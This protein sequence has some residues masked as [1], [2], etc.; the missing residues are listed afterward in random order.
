MSDILLHEKDYFWVT[1]TL[2]AVAKRHANNRIVSA[3][4]GWCALHALGRSVTMHVK[5]V[6]DLC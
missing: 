3:L 5:S 6:S 1:E 2:K 4:E